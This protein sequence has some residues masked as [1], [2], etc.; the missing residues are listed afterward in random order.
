MTVAEAAKAGLIDHLKDRTAGTSKEV[1]LVNDAEEW[2]VRK[3]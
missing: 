2:E 3:E 1:I